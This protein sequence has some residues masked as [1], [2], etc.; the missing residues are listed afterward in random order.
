MANTNRTLADLK[1]AIQTEMQL[2]PGLISD[3]ERQSFINDCLSDVAGTNTFEKEA[4]IPV[5]N[6]E[7]ELPDDF[8]G[9]ID[10]RYNGTYL[11]PLEI[12][13][14][15][16]T[17]SPIG[18]I[19]RYKTLELYPKPDSGTVRMYYTYV[20]SPLVLDTDR[21]D[22]PNGYDLMI[23]DYGVSRAHRK[24]GNIGLARE[25]MYA[26]ETRKQ[27]LFAEYINRKNSRVVGIINK[28]AGGITSTPFDFL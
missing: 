9:I 4:D 22:L 3:L 25:Y 21:P 19:L 23:I 15:E 20:P 11:V 18:Y 28:E 1:S 14:I 5:V 27:A 26:Y 2:D 24:N 17:G 13:K 16:S 12:P 10:V 6:G 7:V 8:R